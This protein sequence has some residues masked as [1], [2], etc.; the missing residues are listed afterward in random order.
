MQKPIPDMKRQISSVL[1]AIAAISAYGQIAH[2]QVAPAYDAVD[3][4]PN[5]LLQI[6]TGNK[7]GLANFKGETALPAAYDSI[8]SFADNV[9]LL[10]NNSKFAGIVGPTGSLTD[11][12]KAEYTLIPGQEFFSDGLLSVQNSRGRCIFINK[13]GDEKTI[14]LAAAYPYFDG[15]AAVSNFDLTS[16]NFSETKPAY[17]NTDG[18]EVSIPLVE[19][20][21]DLSFISSFRDGRAVIVYKK[22]AYWLDK[23]MN[24]TPIYTDNVENKKNMVT[25]DNKTTDLMYTDQGFDIYAK[26]AT[27]RFNKLMQLDE[28]EAGSNTV[29]KY[30]KNI[31]RVEKPQGLIE[32]FDVDGKYGLKYKE[33]VILPAQF[34]D[35]EIVDNDY[36][37]VKLDGKWGILTIDPNN[38]FQFKLNDNEPIGFN[39]K[40]FNTKLATL[41]PPYIKSNNTNVFSKSPDCVI[42]I[43]SRREIENVERNTLTYDCKLSIPESLTDNLSQHEYVFALKYD[44]LLSSD[45]KITIP[46]W[47]VKFYEVDFQE[48]NFSITPGETV[49]VEFDLTKTDAARNDETNYFKNVELITPENEDDITLDKITENHFTFKVDSNDRDRLLF[50]IN[51][52]ESGCPTISYPF[53]MVFTAPDPDS[54][55]KNISVEIND[56]R[57]KSRQASKPAQRQNTPADASAQPTVAPATQPSSQPAQ[58]PAAQ[59]VLINPDQPETT[60]E[61]PADSSLNQ[62]VTLP[63]TLPHQ[64]DEP[65]NSPASLIQPTLQPITTEQ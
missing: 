20:L 44:G 14:Q 27:L 19:K 46:E 51:I 49:S 35:V 32:K 39:H 57:R 24:A 56:L 30:K 2:W 64:L 34:G 18:Q 17:L 22:K 65:D 31:V 23:S 11:L 52:T 36:A 29:Y 38:I 37:L 48:T 50:T 25:F 10:F 8:G 7:Y 6:K 21:S 47:Y 40:S 58:E 55:D 62:T 4:L 42:H 61:T 63:S 28:I 60:A 26:N 45:Y 59:P 15:Y 53:E 43:E 54:K 3:I 12:S 13:Q 5:G 16:K 33:A 41:M 1:L 9:A